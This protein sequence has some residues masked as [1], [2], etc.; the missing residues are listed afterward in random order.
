VCSRHCIDAAGL[1]TETETLA[2]ANASFFFDLN[3]KVFEFTYDDWATS[4]CIDKLPFQV[5]SQPSG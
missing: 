5:E 1:N 4:S 2:Q 3:G